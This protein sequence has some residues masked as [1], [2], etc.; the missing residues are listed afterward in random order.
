MFGDDLGWRE[1]RGDYSVIRSHIERV[2]PGFHAYEERV[3]QPGG[4][5]LPRPPHDSRTFPTATGKARLT[6]N[7]PTAAQAPEGCLLLQTVRSHDQFNT[8]VY[9]YDDRYRG[10]HGGRRVVLVNPED[11]SV[12]GLH[13]GDM[14]DLISVWKDEERRAPG[15]RVVAYPTA[16][17]CA[18]TYFPEANILVPLD[19]TADVSNTPASKSVPIR[20]ELTG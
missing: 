9:G 20:L 4:F 19:S 16:V 17:G 14:V 12:R 8:T 3:K 13:D 11:L 10:I 1:M 2:V 18:A 6:V 5:M 7:E 15:F